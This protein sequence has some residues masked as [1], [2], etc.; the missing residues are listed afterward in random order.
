MDSP[1]RI[2]KIRIGTQL[3]T[4]TAWSIPSR[5]TPQPHWKTA[6]STPYAAAMESRF[7]AAALIGTA[8]ERNTMA[9]RSTETPTTNAI[10]S[11]SRWSSSSVMSANSG[12]VPV[13]SVPVGS[14]ARRSA[15]RPG[16]RASEGPNAGCASSTV[17]APSGESTG[18]VTPTM[19]VLACR[20]RTDSPTAPAA[21]RDRSTTTVTVPFAPGPY[22]AVTRSNARRVVRSWE[23]V[24]SSCGQVRMSSAGTAIVSISRA[25]A[26]AHGSGR[27][28]TRRAHRAVSGVVTRSRERRTRRGSTRRPA[29]RQ[30]TGTSV[31]EAAS[32]ATTAMAVANPKVEYVERPARRRPIRETS[33]V[34]A[35]NTTDRPAVAIA[36]PADSATSW[37]WRR[38]STWR[39]TSSRA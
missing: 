38:N 35:A 25:A 19:S 6:T 24:D 5:R 13:T 11:Q 14:S 16:I 2:A 12:V 36:R 9:S 34:V 33:T 31:R 4:G 26:T 23:A 15:T 37:P 29:N 1:N 30:N 28:A 20:A 3:D 10:T 18:A 21:A 39:V 32:T 17:T 7:I 8:T 27:R 22:S